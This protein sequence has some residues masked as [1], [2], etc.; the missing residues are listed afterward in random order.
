MPSMNHVP[1]WQ[2]VAYSTTPPTSGP[3]W[4]RWADR[5]FYPDGLPDELIAHNLEHGNIVVSYKSATIS[6]KAGRCSASA[7]Y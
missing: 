5:G 2:S 3:H 6:Q 4:D 1:E 7:R